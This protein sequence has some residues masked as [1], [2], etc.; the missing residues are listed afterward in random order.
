MS[1]APWKQNLLVC[2]KAGVKRQYSTTSQQIHRHTNSTPARAAAAAKLAKVPSLGDF[3]ADSSELS[4]EESLEL[5]SGTAD[6]ASPRKKQH[7]RLPS[8]LKTEIPV[9]QEFGRIKKD[10]R[11]LKLHTQRFAK[12]PGVR[13]LENVGEE[14]RK[15]LRQLLSCE[16]K[17]H[18]EAIR[19]NRTGTYFGGHIAVG[20]GLR[21]LIDGGA[22]HFAKTVELIKQKAPQILVECLTGDYQG[23]LKYVERVAT[24]GLDVYA[25]N[26]ETVENLQKYVR[27]RRAGFKQSLSVLEHAKKVRP[28]LVTKTSMMLGLGESDEEVLNALKALRAIDVDVVTFGQYMRPTKKHMKVS[29]YVHPDKFAHW[30]EVAENLGFKYVASGPLVRSSYKAGEFYIKNILRKGRGQELLVE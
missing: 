14:A 13:T 20:V 19:P 6:T 5:K 12:R 7:V 23:E 30:Q 26:I 9:G 4:Y 27:D 21:Y 25:H 24:S 1:M 3:L 29:E 28:S 8:W 10:L 17:S 11:G 22:E 2:A 15:K 16:D 18:T